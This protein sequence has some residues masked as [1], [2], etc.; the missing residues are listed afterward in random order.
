MTEFNIHL[1]FKVVVFCMLAHC[2][3]VLTYWDDEIEQSQH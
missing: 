2:Y 3:N 1:S